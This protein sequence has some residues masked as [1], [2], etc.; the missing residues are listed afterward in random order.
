MK[1]PRPG[2]RLSKLASDPAR[3]ICAGGDDSGLAESPDTLLR[4]VRKVPEEKP[5]TPRVLGVDDWAK[6]KGQTYGT[7]LVD[8]EKHQPID[9]LP[10]RSA[11]ALE[12]WL[13]DHPGV[14][15]ITRD[16]SGEYAAGATAGAPKATQVADRFHLLQNLTDTLTRMFDR[17]PQNLREA[18]KQAAESM[19]NTEN[20]TAESDI[21]EES[22]QS[23]VEIDSVSVEP[24]PRPHT[25]G[26]N[27]T[28]AQST[29]QWRFDQVKMLQ[30]QSLSQRVVAKQLQI[31]RRTVRRYWLLDEYPKRQPGPQAVS[32]VTPYSSYLLERWQEGEQN[33]KVLWKELQEQGYAGSYASVWRATKQLADDGVILIEKKKPA[34]K[35]PAL[36]PRRAAWI[37]SVSEDD[38]KPEHVHL[39][40]AL[41]NVCQGAT[42]VYRLAQDFGEMIRKRRADVLDPWLLKAKECVVG[43]FQRFSDS[44]KRD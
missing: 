9:V 31:D 39:R 25:P 18:A 17:Q 23:D 35:V 20:Q 13:A 26:Q 27:Q 6:K 32:S 36:S 40:N 12:E 33:R 37:F 14:E 8:L 44:L 41:L 4:M 7:I 38:L 22:A 16:R 3:T 19:S 15:I 11:E 34:L 43:E 29:A 5:E 10:D 42:E 24:E 2:S 1:R 28:Q 30:E 21:P